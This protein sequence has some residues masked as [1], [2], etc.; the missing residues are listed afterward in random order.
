MSRNN[1]KKYKRNIIYTEKKIIDVINIFHKTNIPCAFVVDANNK[2]IGSITD[3]DIRRAILKKISLNQNISKIYNK[4]SH[5]LK[6]KDSKDLNKIRLIA[7]NYLIRYLPVIHNR[8]IIEIIDRE[9]IRLS[10]NVNNEIV[11]MAGGLG[12][13]LL[14]ITKQ[15]P[16]PLI[17]INGKPIISKIISNLNSQGFYNFTIIVNYLGN[18][19][20]KYVEKNISKD[21]KIKFIKEKRAL[22]TL[23]GLSLIKKISE[24][25]FLI[26]ADV[27]SNLNF[28]NMLDFHEKNKNL[29]TLG[30]IN[31]NTSQ[32]Y[33]IVNYK[34][35]RLIKI[36]EKPKN[37]DTINSGIYILNKKIIKL[38]KKNFKIDAPEFLNKLGNKVKIFPIYEKWVDIGT[39]EELR[40]I[41]K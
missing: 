2:Y 31:Y 13:R 36:K 11:I 29:V 37:T 10:S 15:I 22:G 27:I 5:F 24:N 38:I 3:G 39:H 30:V 6:K 25:F 7:S 41:R 14:P 26:N 40:K 8:K 28:R 21:N 12:K 32:S 33:G 19:I 4:N 16:K 18:K 9:E 23:G 17:S 1:L 35:G 20:I 34:R